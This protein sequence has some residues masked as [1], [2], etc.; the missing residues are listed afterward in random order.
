MPAT[1]G[2]KRPMGNADYSE[3]ALILKH[4]RSLTV[5]PCR[6]KLGILR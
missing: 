5:L 3:L 4:T 1:T 6:Q 2:E